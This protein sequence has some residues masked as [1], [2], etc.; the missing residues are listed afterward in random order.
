MKIINNYSLEWRASI[1]I[2]V[3]PLSEY[4]ILIPSH[5]LPRWTGRPSEPGSAPVRIHAHNILDTHML[6]PYT[7][8]HRIA[9]LTAHQS[10][11]SL[12]IPAGTEGSGMNVFSR[13]LL[14]VSPVGGCPVISDGMP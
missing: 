8:N 5:H 11:L 13:S 2:T 4:S 1:P 3:C 14:M 10:L 7:S 6:P 12:I 9:F